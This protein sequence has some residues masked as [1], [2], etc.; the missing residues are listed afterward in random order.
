MNLS[1]KLEGLIAEV[2]QEVSENANQLEIAS[3]VIGA[4]ARDLVFNEFGIITGRA[5][6]DLDIGIQ[7]EDWN[8]FAKLKLVLLNSG[9]FTETNNQHRLKYKDSINIDIVPFGAISDPDN[10]ISW[11]PDHSIKMSTLGFMDAYEDACLCALSDNSDLVVR[12]ASICG[13]TVLKLIS[14]HEGYPERKKDAIDLEFMMRQYADAGNHER[15][16][17]EMSDLVN[18]ENF[19]YELASARFFGRDILKIMSLKTTT[20]IMSILEK[21]TGDQERYLL[22]ED[23]MGPQIKRKDFEDVLTLLESFKKGIHD[24]D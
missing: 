13:L 3:F 21:Q 4:M 19:D 17:E 9:N 15:F 5:T 6:L 16:Y 10:S 12:V 24:H 1:G 20:F 8:H 14:W 2:L 23:M 18:E 22:I 7:V 11:P